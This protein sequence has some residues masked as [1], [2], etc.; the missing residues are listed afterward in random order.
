M[1]GTTQ[2]SVLYLR[3]SSKD[4]EKGYSLDAQKKL[5][6]TY[7][8]KQKFKITK[9]YR[10][11]ESA[12]GKQVRK[13]F[14][15]MLK[16]VEKNN[17]QNILCEKVDRLTRNPKDATSISDWINEDENRKVHFVK[18]N[19]VLD[20]NT[21]AHENLV[22]D[23]KVAIARFYTN[24]LSE[25][26]RK[27]QK[28]KLAQGWLPRT[29]PLGY[30]TIGDEGQKMHVIDEKFAPYI[31]KA[32]ELYATG[33][34]SLNKLNNELYDN[35]LRS[36]SGKR[37]SK[38]LLHQYLQ[39]PFYKGYNR[40]NDEV[41]KGKQTPLV[42]E[43]VFERV[44]ELL[45]RNLN[46]AQYK[47]HN[48]LFQGLV[49]CEACSGSVTWQLQK[50]DF[51]GNCNTKGCEG[52]AERYL[53]MEDVE[54]TLLPMLIEVAPKSERVLEWLEQALKESHKEEIEFTKNKR[55]ALNAQFEKLQTRL[56]R[57]YDD[58][59]DGIISGEDYM[60]R[61]ENYTDE[62]KSVRK[63]LDAVDEGNSKY[64]EAGYAIHELAL[65]AKDIYES[66]NASIDE[67]RLLL[68]YVFSNIT[69]NQLEIKAN[70]TAAF[71]FL[72][73]WMP[74]MNET[75]E[76]QESAVNKAQTASL[77][78]VR[79][80]M[81]AWKDSFRTYDWRA[82]FPTPELSTKHIRALTTVVA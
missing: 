33:N 20:K 75:F 49:T 64:Y 25:E 40:W 51:Y 7:A 62:Q 81:L 43:E 5:L 23:M 42:S 21:R 6:N 50:G 24:N 54:H 57:L 10:I 70:Y 46:G 17:I 60:R 3:V 29:A 26:V 2:N 77:E 22:W 63:E 19:F 48:T 65:K 80:V 76:L 28:E 59:V 45:T 68:S 18:E 39:N 47:K 11:S 71:E 30:K 1:K 35:G 38:S 14:N 66:K 78:T 4:Q 52:R 34:Y 67:R 44:Q 31:K 16:Y 72:A 13:I 79:S 12:S 56:D 53:K 27:G 37:V 9:I 32:F 41:T 15:E 55:T 69:R 58:K 73:E 82:A 61:Y 36:K 8:G 74:R